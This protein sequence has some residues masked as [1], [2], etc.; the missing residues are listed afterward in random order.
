MNWSDV[1]MARGST[2]F[3]KATVVLIGLLILAVCILGLPLVGKE[4][5]E[6]YPGYVIYPIVG[7][8]YLT[9]I[10]FYYALFQ[11]L[12][13]LG[14][15]D[16]NNAFSELSVAALKRI[17]ASAVAI[18]LVF[19][20]ILPFFLILGQQDD[21]PGIVLVNLVFVFAS[22]VIAVF[23]AVLQKL[24]KNAIDIQSELDLTV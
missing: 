14:F 23:A 10:P 22:M 12:R 15:I 16:R 5:L 24:L 1:V 4:L 3:L 19:V 21:A 20:A 13:L 17:K 6:D 8:L 7:G 18:S 2:L 9:T 11:A